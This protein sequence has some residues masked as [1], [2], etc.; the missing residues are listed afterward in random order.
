MDVMRTATDRGRPGV[1][2]VQHYVVD[3]LQCEQSSIKPTHV[4][5]IFQLISYFCTATP[6]FLHRR[7]EANSLTQR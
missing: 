2:R 1:A 6:Q 5:L 3:K 7:N 4:V